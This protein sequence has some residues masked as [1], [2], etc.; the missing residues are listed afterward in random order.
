MNN[1]YLLTYTMYL[2]ANRSGLK[3]LFRKSI[4]DGLVKRGLNLKLPPILSMC[5]KR[6]FSFYNTFSIVDKA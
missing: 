1:E 3:L 6:M 4:T 5:K 2:V